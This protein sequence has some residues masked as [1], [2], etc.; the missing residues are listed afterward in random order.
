MNRCYSTSEY[1][2]ILGLYININVITFS[3]VINKYWHNSGA[4]LRISCNISRIDTHSIVSNFES[5]YLLL[6]IEIAGLS[7]DER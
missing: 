6:I 1:N 4:K 2:P 5:Q 3:F 7:S